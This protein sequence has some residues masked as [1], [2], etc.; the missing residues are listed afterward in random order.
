MSHA[1]SASTAPDTLLVHLGDPPSLAAAATVRDPSAVLPWHPVLHGPADA[2][3]RRAVRRT[4]A[5]L[6]MATPIF[7]E[8]AVPEG[9][10]WAP[11]DPLLEIAVLSR[12]AVVAGLHGCSSILWPIQRGQISRDVTE[13]I[14]RAESLLDA[15]AVGAEPA[16]VPAI[17]LPVVDLDDDQVLDL[18][19]GGGLPPAGAWPCERADEAACGTCGSCRRWERAARAIGLDWPWRSRRGS[20]A[21]GD[22]DEPGVEV[23]ARIRGGRSETVSS[24]PVR[25][26]PSSGR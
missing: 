6:G 23:L 18:I 19:E 11:G 14:E 12:A 10:R 2:A 20:E 8:A 25:R 21:G 26:E 16:R 3:R 24:G 15:M 5:G 13:S 22:A 7:D 4:A 1:E 17:E 9:A